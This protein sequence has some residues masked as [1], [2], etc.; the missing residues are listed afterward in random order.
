MP[1]HSQQS[2]S[3]SINYDLN[4]SDNAAHFCTVSTRSRRRQQWKHTP[5]EVEAPAPADREQL[6]LFKT[7]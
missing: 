6:N 5:L 4:K 3:N 7:S 2:N 1:E